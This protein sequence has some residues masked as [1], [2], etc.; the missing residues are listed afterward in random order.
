MDSEHSTINSNDEIE[1]LIKHR[2]EEITDELSSDKYFRF[3][4]EKHHTPG[5][6]FDTNELVEQL[7][8]ASSPKD[9]ISFARQ[10][11]MEPQYDQVKQKA[12]HR[13]FT[14]WSHPENVNEQTIFESSYI[15]LYKSFSDEFIRENSGMQR[16]VKERLAP[17]LYEKMMKLY[18]MQ[19]KIETLE[20]EERDELL[21][22]L[23]IEEM[24]ELIFSLPDGKKEEFVLSLPKEKRLEQLT[25]SGI[26]HLRGKIL[27][28]LELSERLDYAEPGD[29]R[30]SIL[31]EFADEFSAEELAQ[32]LS[33]ID[34]TRDYSP[35]HIQRVAELIP[36]EP[37]YDE[38]KR[39]ALQKIFDNYDRGIFDDDP[40][41]YRI[42]D[43]F[44]DG[45]VD[46]HTDIAITAPNLYEYW[47]DYRSKIEQSKKEENSSQNLDDMSLEDLEKLSTQ[48]DEKNERLSKQIE[49]QEKKAKLIESIK[50]KM[51]KTHELETRLGEL[52]ER[53]NGQQ[54]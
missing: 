40:E 8:N 16:V 20:K 18:V 34:L 6:I 47:K 22:S 44:S 38:V 37:E 54:H 43:V 45:Y 42:L 46:N 7:E 28:T 53:N 35:S 41:L 29:E 49:E 5:K 23:S 11:P 26:E 15:E 21:L 10:I 17:H 4:Y 13:M 1:L 27:D 3:N 31:E 32:E 51:A 12:F 19:E 39:V 50:A 2:R 9:I 48:T 33:E 36:R 30:I 14:Q 24:D 25:N 52:E